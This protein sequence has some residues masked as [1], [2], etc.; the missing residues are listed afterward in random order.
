MKGAGR[1]G[2]THEKGGEEDF[3]GHTTRITTPPETTGMA[4]SPP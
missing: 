4:G 1:A 3:L 2:A